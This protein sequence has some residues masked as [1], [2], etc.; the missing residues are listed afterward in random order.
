MIERAHTAL[1]LSETRFKNTR[2]RQ[3]Q[4]PCAGPVLTGR[5]ETA[6]RGPGGLDTIAIREVTRG[7]TSARN[8]HI[9]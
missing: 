2:H 8:L 7:E 1:S 5:E 6:E 4:R 9:P 3:T